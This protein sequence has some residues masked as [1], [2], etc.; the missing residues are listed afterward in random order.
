MSIAQEPE[1]TYAFTQQRRIGV[2]AA[3]NAE[4]SRMAVAL[5]MYRREPGR[6]QASTRNAFILNVLRMNDRRLESFE[7][8][9][10]VFIDVANVF[11]TRA[12]LR[13]WR[14]TRRQ[15]PPARG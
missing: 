1:L 8:F 13:N 10:S 11:P 12:H 4:R 14:A 5:A 3:R 7:N 15:R 6:D 9:I 2:R